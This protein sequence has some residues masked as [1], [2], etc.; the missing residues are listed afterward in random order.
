MSLRFPSRTATALL[1]P[2][3][4]CGIAALLTCSAAMG[5]GRKPPKEPKVKQ[6]SAG[7]P[8]SAE[9]TA[10][11][12]DSYPDAASYPAVRFSDEIKGE[13]AG[14]L[15]SL[16]SSP[17]DYHRK[18]GHLAVT[19]RWWETESHPFLDSVLPG[20]RFLRLS[21]EDYR[22]TDV[23]ARYTVSALR[24]NRLYPAA[25]LNQL[26]LG[27][28]FTFDT[29]EMTT[30]AKIAVLFAAFGKTAGSSGRFRDGIAPTDSSP[31]VGFPAITF[32][33]VERGEWKHP[34]HGDVRRGASADCIVDGW[35]R[36]FFIEFTGRARAEPEFLFTAQGEFLMRFAGIPLP[37]PTPLQKRGSHPTDD[38][39]WGNPGDTVK[40]IQRARALEDT[41]PVLTQARLVGCH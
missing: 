13:A 6:G 29:T 22:V 10:A 41:G 23:G 2:V 19:R 15:T 7:K 5:W 38:L 3:V 9:S 28:G 24:D 20:V 12:R 34:K 4:V 33:S 14:M 17:S 25:R 32:L 30:I 36:G 26:L 18:S 21:E 37:L 1:R 8:A 31:G 27:A 11:V 40:G 39:Q 35:R 16:V